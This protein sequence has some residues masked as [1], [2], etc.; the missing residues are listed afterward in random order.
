[1]FSS[2]Q[3]KGLFSSCPYEPRRPVP[4]CAF[5]VLLAFCLYF[6][7]PVGVVRI[8]HDVFGIENPASAEANSPE[9]L[10]TAHPLARMLVENPNVWVIV[11]GIA[12]AVFVAPVTEEF[13]FRLL[14]QGWLETA[15]RRLRRKLPELRRLTVGVMP[16]AMAAFLFAGLHFRTASPRLEAE[17]I[18]FLVGVRTAVNLLTVGIMIAWIRI[19]ARA[20]LADFGISF[21]HWK[22][23]IKLGMTAFLVVTIP[24]YVLLILLQNL[25][26]ENSVVDPLPLLLLAVVLGG[27][28]YRTHR[29]V[30]SIMLHMAFNATG[31]ILALWSIQ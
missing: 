6:F 29:I 13:L 26:P 14:L 10:D 3:G 8:S 20:T 4:W 21:S 5:D 25:L 15:E 23:D 2:P 19:A 31:V 24:V 1:M 7:M 30:S 22:S 28:Y 9:E 18:V 27:L 16:V 11:L 12:T 17:E